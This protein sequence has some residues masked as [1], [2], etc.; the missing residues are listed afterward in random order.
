MPTPEFIVNLRRYIGH[1]P[2]WLLGSSTVVLREQGNSTQV[3][4]GRR[5][6]N[7]SWTTID[8]IV[9]PGEPPQVAA[10]RE[11]LEET[12]LEVSI[13]RL[14][15]TGV[16]GPIS[17]ANGDVCSFV[18]HCYRA[19]VVSGST[20]TGDGENSAVRWFGLDGLPGGITPV[21]RR[22]IEVAV[23]NAPEVVLAGNYELG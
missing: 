10:A 2:L 9:E 3:L 23:A 8:G 22:R 13:E 17:Y 1:G 6:D 12:E 4:L 11:C 5:A 7:G 14:V 19:H 16:V 20:G 18:D 15:M 21:S